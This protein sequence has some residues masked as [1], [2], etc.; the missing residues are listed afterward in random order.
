MSMGIRPGWTGNIAISP[1][2]LW[3]SSV[4][5]FMVVSVLMNRQMLIRGPPHPL[6][7]VER[8]VGKVIF[9]GLDVLLPPLS[10]LYHKTEL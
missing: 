7:R 2:L 8:V 4:L 3:P 6:T 10:K 1:I 9:Q 5:I